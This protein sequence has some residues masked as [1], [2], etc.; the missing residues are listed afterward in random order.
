[1]KRDLEIKYT[2][3]VMAHSANT[4]RHLTESHCFEMR[5]KASRWALACFYRGQNRETDVTLPAI[6][7]DL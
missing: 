4:R 3:C 1:M 6:I 7:T 2:A 5:G